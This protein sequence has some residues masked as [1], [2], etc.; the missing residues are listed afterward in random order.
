MRKTPSKPKTACKDV[1]IQIRL[2]PA[3]KEL[4]AHAARLRQ[5][6]LSHFILENACDAAEQ[7]LADQVHF[8]LPPEH[9]EAFC[10]ALDAPPR[11]CPGL[12]K[13]LTEASVLDGPGDTA[14]QGPR[15][16]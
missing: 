6:T 11:D 13:L 8:V 15:G 16:N 12:K 3:Q 9:W 14:P 4:I 1:K 5:T 2:Q 10:K 7:V